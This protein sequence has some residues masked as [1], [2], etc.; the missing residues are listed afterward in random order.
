M[1]KSSFIFHSEWRRLFRRLSG[2]DVKQLIEMMC[3]YADG[4]EPQDSPDMVGMAF[5]CIRN[6]M[7]VDRSRYENTC[8]KRREAAHATARKQS[9]K[10]PWLTL[11]EA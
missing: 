2:E 4:N 5:D 7:D 6:L 10:A 11:T 1:E 8:K 9:L 3:E